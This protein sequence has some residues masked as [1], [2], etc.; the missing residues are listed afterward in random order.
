[1][2]VEKIKLSVGKTVNLGNY[3]SLRVDVQFEVSIDD[4]DN[5]DTSFKELRQEVDSRLQEVIDQKL[6]GED[7]FY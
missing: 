4:T 1:M 3:E 2:K 5:I 6:K 7:N